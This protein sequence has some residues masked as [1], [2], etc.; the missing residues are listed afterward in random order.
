M[1]K[2]DDP[3]KQEIITALKN[4]GL[5][6]TT[7]SY[8]DMLRTLRS[9]ITGR[10]QNKNDFYMGFQRG[11]QVLKPIFKNE[12]ISHTEKNSSESH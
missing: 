8:T 4:H 3:T 12:A 9:F 7:D 5:L 11:E 1:L 2:D 10:K 6:V